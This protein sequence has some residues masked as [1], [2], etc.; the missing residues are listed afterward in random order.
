MKCI[1]R[2][3]L[4]HKSSRTLEGVSAYFQYLG[5]QSCRVH[6][7][8]TDR[9]RDM[10]EAS[11]FTFKHRD[12]RPLVVSRANLEDIN[13]HQVANCIG[14]GALTECLS[15]WT[16]LLNAQDRFRHVCNQEGQLAH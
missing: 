16:F 9:P 5:L 13:A 11:P 14:I 8:A 10:S 4:A 1:R 12:R 15:P 6:G 7:M 2:S 3:P